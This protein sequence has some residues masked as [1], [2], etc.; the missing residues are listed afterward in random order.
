VP[1]LLQR[2]KWTRK[3][4]NLAVWDIVLIVDDKNPRGK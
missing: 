1:S 3:E 2:T 4:H